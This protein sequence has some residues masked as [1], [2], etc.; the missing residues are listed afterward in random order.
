M[1]PSQSPI[2]R[3]LGGTL[4]DAAVA[5]AYKV[6]EAENKSFV[7]AEAV[8]ELERVTKTAEEA[9]ASLQLIRRI[10]ERCKFHISYPHPC[11]FFC[12]VQ[13]SVD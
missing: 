13:I 8:K 1:W 6:A 11:P 12:C 10:Y 2:N 7:A 5:A 3:H 4:E 9:E